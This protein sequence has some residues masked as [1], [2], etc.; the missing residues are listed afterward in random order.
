MHRAAGAPWMAVGVDDGVAEGVADAVSV[1]ED[2]GLALGVAVGE[3]LGDAVGDAEAVAVAVGTTVLVPVPAG[4]S[5]GAG[6]PACC[7]SSPPSFCPANQRSNGVPCW[8]DWGLSC[9]NGLWRRQEKTAKE[10]RRRNGE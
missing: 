3:P 6:G 5:W 2:V 4:R 1:S 8:G 7:A 9:S 10:D